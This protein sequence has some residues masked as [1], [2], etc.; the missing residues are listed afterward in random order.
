MSQYQPGFGRTPTC[1]IPLKSTK[2]QATL[3]SWSFLG[4]LDNML[5]WC[6]LANHCCAALCVAH[7]PKARLSFTTVKTAATAASLPWTWAEWRGLTTGKPAH[8]C[9]TF[10]CFNKCHRHSGGPAEYMCLTTTPN[11]LERKI[12]NQDGAEVCYGSLSDWPELDSLRIG[13]PNRVSNKR[14]QREC[15]LERDS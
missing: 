3:T 6:K 12:G 7:L 9:V 15:L 10:S 13:D 14:R 4:M 8:V 5:F 2:L 11:I 1:S